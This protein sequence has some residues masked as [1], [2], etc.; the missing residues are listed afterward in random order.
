MVP[1]GHLES[2]VCY[3]RRIWGAEK[4][5]QDSEY[6]LYQSKINLWGR[7]SG[8]KHFVIGNIEFCKMYDIDFLNSSPSERT[9]EAVV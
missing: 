5:I 2:L 8:Y 7:G 1:E 4:F 9:G 3:S 6:L